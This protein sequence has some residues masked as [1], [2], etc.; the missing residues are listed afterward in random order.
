MFGWSIY[1]P[2]SQEQWKVAPPLSKL[3]TAAISSQP[4]KVINNKQ[5]RDILF[6]SS[7]ISLIYSH[8]TTLKCHFLH[9]HRVHLWL[10]EILPAGIRHGSMHTPSKRSSSIYRHLF[11]PAASQPVWKKVHCFWVVLSS[12]RDREESH[13][14]GNFIGVTNVGRSY[15][16]C[17]VQ[18]N[19]YVAKVFMLFI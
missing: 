10:D 9:I 1:Q 18:Y 19:V 8:W 13:Q 14:A 6:I 11:L 12:E 16:R 17:P 7:L 2:T 15:F 3:L 4:N 5:E